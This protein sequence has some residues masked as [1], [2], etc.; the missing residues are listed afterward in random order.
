MS[1]QNHTHTVWQCAE[2]LNRLELLFF[3]LIAC[4]EMKKRVA[5][6][7]QFP[8]SYYWRA[9]GD[10][11][12]VERRT[13]GAKKKFDQGE[14]HRSFYIIFII[15]VSPTLFCSKAYSGG[16]P[17]IHM[18]WFKSEIGAQIDSTQQTFQKWK[19]IHFGWKF[20]TMKPFYTHQSFVWRILTRNSRY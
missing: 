7:Y 15:S 20:P 18:F 6:L 2:K 17:L 3:L 13:V 11:C 8:F 12:F 10:F 14:W 9:T 1:G 19:A 4:N 5:E 16:S